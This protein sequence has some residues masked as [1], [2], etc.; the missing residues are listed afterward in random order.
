MSVVLSVISG[1]IGTGAIVSVG[2][3]LAKWEAREQ[4]WRAPPPSQEGLP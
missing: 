3:D 4:I 1:L 2:V